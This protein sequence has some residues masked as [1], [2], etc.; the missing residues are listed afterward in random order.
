M[1]YVHAAIQLPYFMLKL[2]RGLRAPAASTHNE[3]TEAIQ[4][5]GRGVRRAIE[6]HAAAAAA[7]LL[8]RCASVSR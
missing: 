7:E 5:R 1:T 3:Q 8:P 6:R 2:A 4:A